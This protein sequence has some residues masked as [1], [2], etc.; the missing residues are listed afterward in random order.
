MKFPIL[1][2]ASGPEKSRSSL[3]GVKIRW[4]LPLFSPGC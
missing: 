4:L 1:H 2:T 3:L